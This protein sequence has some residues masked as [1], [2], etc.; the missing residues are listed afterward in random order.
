MNKKVW[1]SG[2]RG[3]VGKYL[4]DFLINE[5]YN[6]ESLS[7]SDLNDE[8]IK[9]DFS[10]KEDIEELILKKGIPDIF[11]HLGWGRV[12][13]PHKKIHVLQNLKDG[14]NLIDTLYQNGLQK[15]IL[16]GSSS[17]YGDLEGELKEEKE[18][19]EPANN[20]VKGKVSL[21]HYG[22]KKAKEFNKVFIYV[23]LFYAYGAG[24]QHNSLVNQLY[25]N[26]IENKGMQLSPCEHYRDYIYIEDVVKGIEKI[27]QIDK[28]TILNLGSG[29][30]IQ[31]KD[32][33]IK[34]WQELGSDL[35]DLSFGAHKQP[36]SEQSQPK[37]YAD[38]DRLKNLTHWLPSIS[39]KDGIKKTA[40]Q[41]FFLVKKKDLST[42][43]NLQ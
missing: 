15:F 22:L 37:S 1:L 35:I 16:L 43:S 25:K 39:L 13:E 24:Q 5:G 40:K 23:R 6:I 20:Y 17:E 4:K 11:I 14:K 38:L 36:S 10:R 34:F 32:F 18:I 2:S 31:L 3:F 9:I 19:P 28:S 12:Y 33:V 27:S 41:L 29:R 30:V 42:K 8:V 7:Y 21:C 26:S